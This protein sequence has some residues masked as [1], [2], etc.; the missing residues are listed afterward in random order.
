MQTPVKSPCPCRRKRCPRYGRCEECRSHHAQSGRPM[1]CE[2]RSKG[3]GRFKMNSIGNMRLEQKDGVGFLTFPALSGGTRVPPAFST[4]LGGVSEGEFAALNLSFGRGDPDENVRENYRRI[5]LAAGFDPQS[6]VFFRPGSPYGDPPGNGRGPWKRDQAEEGLPECGWIDYRCAG[7]YPGYPLCRLRPPVLS[8][9]GAQGH[10]PNSC[11][12]AGNGIVHRS[13]HRK[14][15]AEEFGTDPRDLKAAVGPSIGKCCYEVDDAVADRVRALSGIHL[16]Q[17]LFPKENG[18][19]QLDLWELNRQLLV[20]AGIPQ[21][22]ITVS[23]SAPVATA[24]CFF[25]TGPPA[26]GGAAWRRFWRFCRNRERGGQQRNAVALLWVP[27]GEEVADLGRFSME[28]EKAAGTWRGSMQSKKSAAMLGLLRSV[29]PVICNLNLDL[30]RAGS[31][32]LGKLK[33]MP[34]DLRVGA[35][36]RPSAGGVDCPGKGKGGPGDPLFPRGRLRRRVV[37]LQP[38]AGVGPGTGYGRRVL[39]YDYRLAPEHPFP[40]ALDD[41]LAVFRHLCR[42]GI[43][44]GRIVLAG[45]SAG[46]GLSLALALCLKDRDEPLPA[47]SFAFPPGPT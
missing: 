43:E 11:G 1:A 28:R 40:A 3:K 26:E 21:T 18:R 31:D 19:Y 22:Q 32:F 27:T 30:K 36:P 35:G 7:P 13:H 45:D 42:E 46:G 41:A 12:L 29:K 6:L 38:G 34:P 5:S 23:G 24:T 16:E 10:R 37:D 33:K 47:G 14:T 9:P 20:G 25:P 8:R 2:S 44:P 39:S 4:R 15:D 17:V